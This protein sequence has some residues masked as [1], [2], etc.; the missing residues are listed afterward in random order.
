MKTLKLFV[1]S[2]VNPQSKIAFASYLV[3]Y[4]ENIDLEILKNSI[5]SKLF[6]N[7]S[8][9]KAELQAFLWALDEILKNG[10]LEQNLQIKVYTDCQ[11]IISLN[12]RKD[13]LEKNNFYS[14]T[15][16]PIN[17]AEL[18]KE[19]FEK[20]K[21]LNIEFIKV[22]GH[23]KS[24]LKDE[25]DLVFSLVDKASRKSLRDYLNGAAEGT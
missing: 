14:K 11:N 13:K 25:T 12:E 20:I 4:Y 10:I 18:Y 2:S 24:Y 23:K 17:N 15:G 6:T 21:S 3:K 22:K 7:T 8:S 9:T 19:F 1:D 5:K 16:K